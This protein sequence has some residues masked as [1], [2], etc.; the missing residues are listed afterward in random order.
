MQIGG[1]AMYCV[2]MHKTPSNKVYIGI[3]S[4]K[5]SKRWNSGKDYNKYFTNAVNKYGWDNIEHIILADNL[6]KDEACKLEIEY[7]NKYKSNDS[8]Y[9]YNITAG[10]EVGCKGYKHPNEVKQRMSQ[11]R[12]GKKLVR[13]KANYKPWNYGKAMSQTQKDKLRE[14]RLGTKHSDET[15][16]KISNSCKGRQFSKEH[17]QRLSEIRKGENNPFYHKDFSPEMKLQISARTKNTIWVNNGEIRK[18][19]HKEDFEYYESIGYK[20]GRNF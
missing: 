20:K 8:R 3:T 11:S 17:R 14:K 10:G 2:Y 9:G 1:N 18:R 16:Q 15:K 7:I 6:T 5:C 19:I 13:R 4:L 12:K